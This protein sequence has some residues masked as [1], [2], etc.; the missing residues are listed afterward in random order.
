MPVIWES[1]F[2]FSLILV[3]LVLYN[4]NNRVKTA[5]NLVVDMVYLHR[6]LSVECGSLPG[7]EPAARGYTYQRQTRDWCC[8]THLA[9]MCFRWSDLKINQF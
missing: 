8:S 9:I 4:N 6:K 3:N 7:I 5:V 1:E 2:F